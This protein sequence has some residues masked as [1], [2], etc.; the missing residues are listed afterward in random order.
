M[1]VVPDADAYESLEHDVAALAHRLFASGT[2]AST[3]QEIVALGE[4]AVDGCDAAG[5]LTV[6]DRDEA[7]TAAAG[8]PLAAQLDKL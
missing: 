4:E 6:D 2:V 1:V 3:L 8:S 7:H 5:I